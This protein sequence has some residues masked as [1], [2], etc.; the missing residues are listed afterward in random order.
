[1][2]SS[3]FLGVVCALGS[4][5][6]WGGGDFSGGLA[7]RRSP[8]A[9]VLVLSTLSGMIVLV[10]LALLRREPWPS[11]A[12]ILWAAAAGLAGIVGLALLYR[13]LATG[14]AAS[15]APIAAVVSAGLP[16]VWS[17]ISIGLPPAIRL[18]G[19]GLALLGIGLVSAAG[20]KSSTDW[21]SIQLALGAGVGF[22]SFFILLGQVEAGVLFTP[23]IVARSVAFVVSLGLLR[24]QHL[25][26]PTLKHNAVALGAGVLDAGGNMLFLLAK[27]LTR[28]DVAAVLSSLYPATTVLLAW[29]ILKE[30]VSPIQWAGATVCLVAV[31]LIAL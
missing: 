5:V 25:P 10:L 22:G 21:N 7:S 16:V 20:T 24:Q 17:A 18:V 11:A 30:R 27:Q 9:H 8:Q 2:N 13:G 28:L 3:H 1:M 12:S 4:A 31:G 14:Q 29:F 19:L 23:L 6:V 26:L 15:V